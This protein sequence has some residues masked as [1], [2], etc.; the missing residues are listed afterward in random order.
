VQPIEE[1]GLMLAALNFAK[2]SNAAQGL[3][4]DAI[5]SC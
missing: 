5:A 2:Y 4:Q 1:N 3:E